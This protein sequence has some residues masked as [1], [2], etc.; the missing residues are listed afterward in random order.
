MNY[1]SEKLSEK[2]S[3][4][5]TVPNSTMAVRGTVFRVAIVYDEGGDSYTT[6]Q[7]F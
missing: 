4:E 7:V 5:V 1:L 2:S 3:Y 6:V